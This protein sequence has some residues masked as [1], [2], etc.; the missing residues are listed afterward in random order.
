M[1]PYHGDRH[2]GSPPPYPAAAAHSSLSPSAA[3][4]TVDC[5]RPAADP[6]VRNPNPPG[7]DLPTAPSLYAT[8][9]AGD[10][11]SSSWMEPPASY[12]APSTAA[13]T[14]PPP[15]YKGEAPETAPYGIFPGTCQIGNF[16]VTRP[17]RSESSQLTSAKGPGTWLGSSE[18]LPSGVGP[19]VFSPQQNTF[20]HK[21]ED[22][23]PYPTHRG[24]LQYP[25]QYPAYDKYMTQL[26]SCSTNV[27]PPVMWTPPA[28][29]S[30][31]VEQM[32]PVMNKNTGE[33][34]S[35][36]SS[37]MN[38]CRINLDYFDCMWNEQKDLGHQTTNKHHGKWSSSASN[39]GDHLLNSLGADHRAARCFGNGRPI[40]ES[41]EMKYD[42]GSFNSKVSPSEVG[43][44][45]SREFSSELPEVN[46]PT[47]DSP[48]WKGAPIAYPPS[49]GIMKNTDNP[50]SVNG[51][52]GYQIE[53]SPEW[54]LKYSELFSK[55]QE[56]SASESVKSD[57]LKTFKLPETRKNTEDNKEVLPV[58]IG[59]HN[60]IGNNASYFPE[61]Q[62]SRRQKCYDSTG[63]CKNMIAANQQENLSVSKAKLLGEDS[64]NHIGSITE[65]SINKGLSP[66]GS[67]PRALVENLSES[68][69]VNVCSQAAGAEECTQAQICAKGGQQP[70]YYSD[71]GGS[72]LKTSSE[73]RS[74]SRAELLK[75]MHD[76]SAM[77][78]STC[79]S[80]PLQGYEEELLQLVI[81][82]LRDASSCIS[83]A[84]AKLPEDK[85]L[86][87][88]D[89]S[90]LS[91]YKNLW[92]EAEASACK[93]KYELQLTRAKLA[94]MENHNNTQVPVDLSKG[95]KIF[96]STIP[97][98]KPQNS[99]AYP[100]N[101]QCQGADSCDGQPPAVN[102][103][104]IDGVDAEVI[105]RLKFLQS[106]LKDCRAF[107]QNNCEEQEEASKKPCAIED[108]VMAR[109]RVLN[110]CPDNIASL[111]QENNNHHQLDTSTNRADN[112]D[113]AVMSRLRILKSLPDNVNPL[114]QESSKHEPDAATG[115]NNFIDNAVM[116]RLRILKSR[117]DNA[118]SLGQES[119]KHEPDASTGT[120]DL[121][122]NAV[123]SRLRILKFRDDNINSLDDA[124]KQHVEAC[125]DQPNWDE[126]G[127]VAKIQAP[128][129]DTASAA[130]GFQ[131][132]LH[133]NNFVRHSEGKDSV[134]GLD[135]PGDA[136]CSD[137]DNGCKAP[138][139]EVNDKTAVQSEGSFPMNI[140]WPLS[141]MDSHICTAGSQETPLIS[142]SVHRYDIFPPKWEHMLKENF[143]HPGK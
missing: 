78:L 26:S 33:S 102:R 11:G 87:D 96:I 84:V 118:N 79:N 143:F 95:N 34:S 65:E 44:V 69:H 30:E 109:L 115:T 110:S 10:W 39:A 49:F 64:S 106:N 5:P 97:N 133:S 125:T 137:E 80:G 132:I 63:D 122:D 45:Q 76:L 24:L 54:S 27:P 38:P 9:A 73:S 116:S 113:D 37:Y 117:P 8:A 88:I 70:R 51:V 112:I 48:C 136:T 82:N 68:L 138:S 126:D 1:L 108:A 57:A 14:P 53:Q 99:T 74:K 103:S 90:Q 40:Q 140:G 3:P 86:D 36:F 131:N 123:M 121:I 128:N 130:D 19:S 104:I 100:A 7:L 29:S 107:C 20:V 15:A 13:A 139:D 141:T 18:V 111:K 62:N 114:G 60:G 2:R 81:Q 6:R 47:V 77:L 42:R 67:A 55:H 50:H 75:Q 83:K 23:E 127:V 85:T 93:L 52:G 56:V 105:E 32:F 94:A 124:I 41:S 142:S 12:M 21:S 61:E 91:I 16:M 46:N 43:Y 92:V 135:S 22:T 98:S 72:M 101:L 4:F 17:L 31:V 89:V 129:G 58:C 71:S 59:V 120:N 66:L 28:N 134:S 35:S 119:S 25:P